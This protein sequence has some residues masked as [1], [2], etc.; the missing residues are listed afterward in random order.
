MESPEDTEAVLRARIA[1][2]EH[3]VQQLVSLVTRNNGW[4]SH[5]DQQT[6]FAAKRVLEPQD[7][8]HQPAGEEVLP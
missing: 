7:L 3:H 4:M 1:L 8:S 6:L 5:A 2:L